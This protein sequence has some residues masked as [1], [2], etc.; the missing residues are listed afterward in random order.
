MDK[1]QGVQNQQP[2]YSND[3]D[4]FQ[5]CADLWGQRMVILACM[6]LVAICGLSY[7]YFSPEKF[8]TEVRLYPAIDVGVSKAVL[9]SMQ[10][11]ND[12]LSEDAFKLVQRHLTSPSTFLGLVRDSNFTAI[13]NKAFHE[14][15]DMEKARMLSQ[16]AK[17]ISTTRKSE[18]EFIT[19][20]FEW[21][22]SKQVVK[23]TTAWV[24]FA[25]EAAKNELIKV[26][27]PAVKREIDEIDLAI[28]VKRESARVQIDNELLRLREVKSI[29][30]K[31]DTRNIADNDILPYVIPEYTNVRNMRALYLIGAEA[32]EAEIKV[33]ESRR[34]RADFDIPDLLKLEEQKAKLKRILLSAG[35]VNPVSEYV[36]PAESGQRVS[37]S[38]KLIVVLSLLFGLTL[39]LILATIKIGFDNRTLTK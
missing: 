22:D 26:S 32:L 10:A 6:L 5:L 39:G 14:L 17:V 11:T 21:Q 9:S 34:N 36:L 20:K 24:A 37:P 13:F 27:L 33:L 38:F 4:V 35:N 19:A 2:D 7:A 29:A 30:D 8:K 23:L 18:S 12:D 28:Q 25:V 15:T 31:I 1:E 16:R 3:I